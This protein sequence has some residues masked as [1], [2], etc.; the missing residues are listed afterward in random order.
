MGFYYLAE[1]ETSRLRHAY[2]DDAGHMAQIVRDQFFE[3]YRDLEDAN[4]FIEQ[5]ANELIRLEDV[6]LI[7]VYDRF[8]RLSAHSYMDNIGR[9]DDYSLHL[10]YAMKAIETGNAITMKHLPEHLYEI[11]APTFM[12]GD[13]HGGKPIG[14][15]VIGFRTSGRGGYIESKARMLAD[16]IQLAVGKSASHLEIERLYIDSIA[17]RLGQIKGL[18]ALIVYDSGLKVVAHSQP[19]HIGEDAGEE[20]SASI[21]KVI[22]TSEEL[23]WDDEKR[24][25]I[26]KFVPIILTDEEGQRYV[27]AV[28]ETSVDTQYIEGSV[29]S[30]RGKM[31]NVALMISLSSLLAIWVVLRVVVVG[32]IKKFSDITDSVSR[33]D[34]DTRVQI[35]TEDEFGSLA[36]SFN[37]MTQE[38]RQSRDELLTA[39]N[40]NQDV[41]AS[42]NES[43]VVVSNEGHVLMAN[44]AA[45]NLLGY[46][47]KELEELHVGAF[48]KGWDEVIG[49]VRSRGLAVFSE[50]VF[51]RKDGG[52]VS[53]SLS[54]SEMGNKSMGVIFGIV[55][56][57]T[58]I[59]ERKR[60]EEAL[61]EYT[62][63]LE[64]YTAE[65]VEADQ[66]MRESEERFRLAFETGPDPIMLT[67]LR[68]GVYVDINKSFVSMTGYP[69]E[70]VVG[71]SAYDDVR[72]WSVLKERDDFLMGLERDSEIR[73]MPMRITLRDGTVRECLISASIFELGGA[74]HILALIRDISELRSAQRDRDQLTEQVIEKSRELEQLV[75]IS[76]HDLRSPLVNVHGFSKEIEMDFQALAELLDG[77]D[78]PAEK[79]QLAEQILLNDVPSSLSYI[80]SSIAKMDSQLKGLLRLSRLGRSDV[81]I[82]EIDMDGLVAEVVDNFGFRIKEEGV[83]VD[84][85]PLPRCMADRDLVSQAVSNI[86]DN[87]LKYMDRSRR[88]VIS[89]SAWK[90]G[91]ASVYCIRDNGK[92][93]RRE[94]QEKVFEIFH[95]LEPDAVTGEGLGLSIVQKAISKC[96]GKVWLESEEGKGSRLYISLPSA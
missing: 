55:I 5:L 29:Q 37:R 51:I 95:R 53:V 27:A 63:K 47:V 22:E 90:E 21:R 82:S 60:S 65:L 46:S 91:P 8:G 30:I 62:R 57:A 17:R 4:L 6:I 74:P 24:G 94:Y 77:V 68:D 35:D 13:E 71:K 28:V 83:R 50:R 7:E 48:M 2:Y 81:D 67:R 16:I 34:L 72:L 20:A 19:G 75:Y 52:N 45:Y 86:M 49:D 59:S 39:R 56:V 70:D 69:R 43:L 3:I 96:G 85:T 76:S 1:S 92:G 23:E 84:R 15:V 87:A 88:G 44:E 9:P 33:G 54:A 32:P 64:A 78:L 14:A 61:R 66:R 89:I 79:K 42:L 73:N 18:S 25:Q 40:F 36:E 11:V 26:S 80:K 41:L 10:R 93:I 31:F 58:D 38:I 12:A